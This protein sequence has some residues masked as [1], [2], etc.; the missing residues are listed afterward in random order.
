M[1]YLPNAEKRNVTHSNLMYIRC[2]E[3]VHPIHTRST[4][5]L[6]MTLFVELAYIVIIMNVRIK[7]ENVG[8]SVI[9]K[10]FIRNRAQ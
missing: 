3:T 1:L 4:Q 5:L 2:K 10:I 7:K 6:L 9:I 8:T